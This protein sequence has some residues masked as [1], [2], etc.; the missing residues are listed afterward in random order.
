MTEKAKWT[1][2]VY[3]AGDNNLSAAGEK[4]L[5]EMS[6]IGSTSDVNV[7]AEFDRI[8]DHHHTKRYHVQ[9]LDNEEPS[10][11]DFSQPTPDERYFHPA[12]LRRRGN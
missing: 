3:L 8:G 11:L 12:G 5:S 6:A 7:I 9:Q 2:M 10:L 4:D 1:F